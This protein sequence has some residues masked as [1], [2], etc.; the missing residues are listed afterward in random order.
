MVLWGVGEVAEQRREVKTPVVVRQQVNGFAGM[1]MNNG[2]SGR[3]VVGGPPLGRDE[4]KMRGTIPAMAGNV[5]KKIVFGGAGGG[6]G[7]GRANGSATATATFGAE[8]SMGEERRRRMNGIDSTGSG[9]PQINGGEP[10]M[11]TATT[12]KK[13]PKQRRKLRAVVRSGVPDDD[14]SSSSSSSGDSDGDGRSKARRLKQEKPVQQQVIRPAVLSHK[15]QVARSRSLLSSSSESGSEDEES[16]SGESGS[17]SGSESD[18]G[19]GSGST[20]VSVSG[21]SDGSGGES[22]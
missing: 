3:G 4:G 9:V 19:S 17:G 21:S 1:M 11:T 2:A 22:D 7:K 15:E 18:S 8:S 6:L 16:D 13:K 14:D 5:G 10:M 20:S 12:I